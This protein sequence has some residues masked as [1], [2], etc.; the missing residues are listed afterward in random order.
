MA[1]KPNI[2][3]VVPDSYRGDVLGHL[4]NPAALTPHLDALVARDAVSY[5]NAFAQNPVCTPSRCSFMTGWYPHVHG[6]RSMCNMLKE[7]EPHLLRSLRNAGYHVWWGGKNDLVRVH[8]SSDYLAHC[9]VKYQ[10]PADFHPPLPLRYPAPLAPDDPRRGGDYGGILS[11]SGTGGLFRDPDTAWIDGAVNL[12]RNPPA[13]RPFCCYLPLHLPH[14]PYVIENDYYQA[15]DPARLPQRI[16]TPTADAQLPPVLDDIRAAF[17]SNRISEAAWL[18]IRRI[19]YAM[20]AKVDSLFGRIVSAL[21]E[22]GTYDQ[23]WIIFFS[24]HGDFAGDYSL[25]E[26]THCTLQDCLLRVPLVIKPPIRVPIKP[27]IRDQLVELIDIPATLYDLLEINPEYDHFGQTLR[28]SLAGEPSHRDAVFAEVGSRKNESGFVNTEVDTLP[29]DSFYFIQSHASRR[30]HGAGSFAVMCRTQR[31][32]LICRPYSGH[33]ELF[34]LQS[35]PGETRNQYGAPTLK[36]IQAQLEQ[37]LLVFF[38]QTADILPHER[39]SRK[40]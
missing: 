19:Y 21:R 35:D 30:H 1:D 15:I 12:I 22:Q 27:G 39:D 6:H 16:P 34:D 17:R 10:I 38:L 13:D 29:P 20:C 23:T 33:H 7:H 25:P 24:D 31:Y 28:G 11:P 26:K 8:K 37:R 3:L 32:K 9:D 4:G 36:T 40:I 2:I 18:D 5:R 14:P